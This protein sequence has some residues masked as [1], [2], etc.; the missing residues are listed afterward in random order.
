MEKILSQE[1][2]DALLK[3]VESGEVE[4]TPEKIDSSKLKAYDFN[5]PDRIIKEKMPTLDIINDQ[6][7]KQFRNDLSI[8][9]RRIVETNSKGIQIKKFSDFIKTLPVPTSLHLF[10]ME[11]LKGYGILAIEAKLIFTLL[12]IFFGG[13]GKTVFRIEGR[14][15]TAIENRLIKKIVNMI[16]L[17]M[18]KAWAVI[19][20][21]NLIHIRSE[22]NP[23]FVSV[24]HPNDLV[25]N[26]TF[27]IEIDEFEGIFIFCIPYSMID[28]IK[29]RLY[30]NFSTD[31]LEVDH[32]WI[33]RLIHL[34][35]QAEVNIN[36]ELG[37]SKIKVKNLIDWKVGDILYLEKELSEPLKVYVEGTPKFLGKP[38]IYRGNR[39]IQIEETIKIQ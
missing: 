26:I 30:S 28:P 13:T 12:D 20:S 22:I 17:S 2:I 33:K 34:L 11:P 1:E 32:N 31:Q 7:S 6:F 36:V 37:R 18:Q 3:G 21:F 19:Q 23:H 25:I 29:M 9:L 15:F 39:A 5:N 24:V 8:A 16:F 27:S 35:E 4:T 14:D 10:K 38:G